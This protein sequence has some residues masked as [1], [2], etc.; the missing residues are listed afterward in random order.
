[1]NSSLLTPDLVDRILAKLGLAAAPSSD[2]EGLRTIY[3]AWCRMVPFDNVRKLI[4]LRRGDT[5]PLPGDDPA[6][7]FH[8]WLTHGTGG[9]CWAGNGALHA[10]L[11][12]LDF[13]ARRGVGTM[14]TAPDLP[15][16]HG[17]VLV[18]HD[19]A[20]YVVDASILHGV[21]LRLDARDAT[22]VDHPAWGVQCGNRDGHWYI[23]W[24]PLHRPE[25]LDCR[26][27]HL[28]VSRQWFH[29]SHERTREMSPFNHALYLRVVRGDRVVGVAHGT[30]IE[31][32]AEG[33]PAARPLAAHDR[34]RFLVEE[35]GLSEEIAH[36]LPDDLPD[37]LASTH[38]A[39][40]SAPGDGEAARL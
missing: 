34:V 6:D 37:P 38:M 16:N 35:V 7:F 30:H 11:L 20:R 32:N 29:E 18:T 22:V 10:L 31:Y 24:R 28:D 2:L 13:A 17:T 39:T 33:P 27:D 23:R 5:G 19:G 36:T 4:H 40:G 8:A 26:L 14:L 1:M 21:P 3:T 25:G 12:S 9:T 15:P